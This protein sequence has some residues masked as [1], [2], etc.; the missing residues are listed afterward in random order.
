MCGFLVQ[1]S[2]ESDDFKNFETANN[3]LEH[4]GP[5]NTGY[6]K[7]AENCKFGFKRLAILDLDSSANQPMLDHENKYVIVFN[8]EIYNFTQLRNEIAQLGGVFKTSHSDT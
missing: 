8:G 7:L 4:R 3:L 1:F 2:S 6:Y 5:D